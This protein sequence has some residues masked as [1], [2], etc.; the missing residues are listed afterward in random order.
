MPHRPLK[1]LEQDGRSNEQSV[2]GLPVLYTG[3]PMIFPFG[4]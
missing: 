3:S 2:H 4:L 1:I